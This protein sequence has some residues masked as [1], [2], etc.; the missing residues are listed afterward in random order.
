ML[1]TETSTGRATVRDRKPNC[2]LYSTERKNYLDPGTQISEFR[3]DNIKICNLARA[4][5][6]M[7]EDLK[8]T[9]FMGPGW[10]KSSD[11]KY[12]DHYAHFFTQDGIQHAIIV[13]VQE[14]KGEALIPWTHADFER[15]HQAM[16]L[17]ARGELKDDV[18]TNLVYNI[19]SA[20]GSQSNGLAFSAGMMGGIAAAVGAVILMTV[21][22]MVKSAMAAAEALEA[23]AYESFEETSVWALIEITSAQAVTIGISVLIIVGLLLAYFLQKEIALNF[24]IGNFSKKY[25]EI[26]DQY[27]YNVDGQVEKN[28]PYLAPPHQVEKFGIPFTQYDGIGITVHNSSEYRGIGVALMLYDKVANSFCAFVMRCD[29]NGTKVINMIPGVN[30]SAEEAFGYVPDGRVRESI[31]WNDLTVSLT[32]SE[33]D[34]TQCAG[35][36]T[37]EDQ[38][39]VS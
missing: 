15:A 14:K 1:E 22:K 36:F 27:L 13:T 31:V 16:Q 20:G 10:S 12:G 21:A 38:N 39:N 24:T 28:Q 34:N 25:I 4:H 6:T 19:T 35:T 8:E 9:N 33:K 23:S 3:N 26:T 30:S 2:T 11:T 18:P 37:I 32:V 5:F 7:L 17:H 29:Y